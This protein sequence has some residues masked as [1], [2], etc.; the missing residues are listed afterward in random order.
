[1]K[2]DIIMLVEEKYVNKF[3]KDGWVIYNGSKEP[4]GIF[5]VMEDN[6]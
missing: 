6:E 1:M 4:S 5:E 3:L 2:N